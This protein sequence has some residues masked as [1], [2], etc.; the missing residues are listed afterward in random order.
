[1]SKIRIIVELDEQYVRDQADPQKVSE[2][3]REGSET[4][5]LSG[6][7]DMVGFSSL[8]RRIDEGQTELTISRDV[9]PP[10]GCPIFDH[11]AV[12]LAMLLVIAAKKGSKEE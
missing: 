10:D 3:V 2:K 8:E 4:G 1:M 7:I 9:L 12:N 5:V 11:V 6:L